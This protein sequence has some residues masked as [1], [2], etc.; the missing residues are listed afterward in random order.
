MLLISLRVGESMPDIVESCI[1]RKLASI[2]R[3][4]GT[5]EISIGVTEPD[6][7]GLRAIEGVVTC[8]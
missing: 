3:A 6:E 7:A 4:L 1:A 2:E 5:R 8:E